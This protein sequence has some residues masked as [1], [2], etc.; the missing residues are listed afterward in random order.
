MTMRYLQKH[1]LISTVFAL[2]L[3]GGTQAQNQ[4]KAA[5]S[6][7]P[8]ASPAQPP[9]LTSIEAGAGDSA[10]KIVENFFGLMMKSQIDQAYDYLTNGTPVA[11][12]AGWVADLKAKT[13]QAMKVCGEVQGYEQISIQNVGTHLMCATYL[14]LGRTYPVRWK[15]YFYRSD[16]TWRLVDIGISA[17][18]ADMFDTKK[19]QLQSS[20]DQ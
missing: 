17:G 14:S 1:L 13:K 3:A 7:S 10:D 6:A 11:E 20:P 2:L 16:K 4:E 15:F 9:P 19:P 5:A 8:A 12:T 18:L